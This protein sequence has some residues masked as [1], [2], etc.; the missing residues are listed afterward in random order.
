MSKLPLVDPATAPPKVRE[1]LERLPVKLNIFRMMAHAET[2][3]R[4]LLRLGS[5]ILA[6]QK[7]NARLRELAIL[8][9]AK[10]TPAE[11]EWVQHVPIAKMVGATDEEVGAIDRGEIEAECLDGDAQLVLR[12]TTEVV[13][14]AKAADTTFEAMKA[15]FSSQ[16]MSS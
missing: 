13:R 11:Y 14:D 4:P 1:V 8:R 12:F 9:V 3:V 15:R 10:M 16:E 7:L 2:N 6:E 5:S